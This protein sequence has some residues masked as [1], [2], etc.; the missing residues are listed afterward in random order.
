MTYIYSQSFSHLDTQKMI[1]LKTSLYLTFPK[2]QQNHN[3]NNIFSLRQCFGV[4]NVTK[5]P[6]L[7]MFFQLRFCLI[8]T[9]SYEIFTISMCCE[10]NI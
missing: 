7:E 2:N 5:T 6:P 8:I 1:W 10:H 4:D 9:P 3:F